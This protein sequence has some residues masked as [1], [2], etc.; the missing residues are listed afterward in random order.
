[1]NGRS[2]KKVEG[3]VKRERK[4]GSEDNEEKQAECRKMK[5]EEKRRNK[6]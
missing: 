5:G 6:A 4:V 1:M 2:E 3:G